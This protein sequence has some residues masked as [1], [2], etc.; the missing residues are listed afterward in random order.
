MSSNCAAFCAPPLLEAFAG[1]PPASW[2]TVGER[3]RASRGTLATVPLTCTVSVRCW[4]GARGEESASRVKAR[5]VIENGGAERLAHEA[6]MAAGPGS[7]S[8]GGNAISAAGEEASTRAGFPATCTAF[9]SA[10]PQKPLP[11]SSNRSA[12]EAKRG[13]EEIRRDEELTSAGARTVV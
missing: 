2:A 9:A 5:K 4:P 12:S 8:I 10:S 7:R 6:S 11:E 13:A 1:L 3:L